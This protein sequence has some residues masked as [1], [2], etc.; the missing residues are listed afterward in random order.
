MFCNNKSVTHYI[1]DSEG[2]NKKSSCTRQTISNC[3]CQIGWWTGLFSGR[4][5]S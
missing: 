1:A 4:Q 2:K 3:S 5:K